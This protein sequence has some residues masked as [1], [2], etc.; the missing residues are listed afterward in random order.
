M[1]LYVLIDKECQIYTIE[2]PLLKPG[3]ASEGSSEIP[4]LQ[5]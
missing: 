1:Q 3:L 5:L 4:K 2:E